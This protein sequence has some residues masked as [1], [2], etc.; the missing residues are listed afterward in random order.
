MVPD[1]GLFPNL[2]SLFFEINL[3]I[4]GKTAYIIP[5]T[6]EFSC[7][8]VKKVEKILMHLLVE[9]KLI[10]PLRPLRK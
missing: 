4:F 2:S 8:F 7:R 5:L 6:S 1:F 9:S 3:I 10:V